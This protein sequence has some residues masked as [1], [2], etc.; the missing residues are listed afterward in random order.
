VQ[1]IPIFVERMLYR[2]KFI[3]HG[4]AACR[5]VVK[6]LLLASTIK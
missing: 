2:G 4:N 1:V 6:L 5:K 3:K